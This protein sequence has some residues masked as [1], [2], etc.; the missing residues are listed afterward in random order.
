MEKYKA[1]LVH[2][3]ISRGGTYHD[4]ATASYHRAETGVINDTTTTTLLC[5]PFCGQALQ[6][7]V[8]TKR[9]LWRLRRRR[10]LQAVCSIAVGAV[11]A[12]LGGITG[13]ALVIAITSVTALVAYLASAVFFGRIFARSARYILT[14]D[15]QKV[16]SANH[17]IVFEP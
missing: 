12:I 16:P 10:L 7:R 14:T 4:G 3:S 17:K 2:I 15:G 1:T 13:A 6:A 8:R 9:E 5:V 11:I